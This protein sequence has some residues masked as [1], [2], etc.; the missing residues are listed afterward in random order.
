[1]QIESIKSEVFIHF[2]SNRLT[3]L[4]ISYESISDSYGILRN[5][6]DPYSKRK[7]DPRGFLKI[8]AGSM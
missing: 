6:K 2:K 5:F 4:I 8:H 3:G 1:M 7:Q